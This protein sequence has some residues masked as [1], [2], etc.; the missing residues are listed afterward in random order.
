MLLLSCVAGTVAWSLDD[1]MTRGLQVIR[2]V[3]LEVRAATAL[4]QL[5]RRS[6]RFRLDAGSTVPAL[7][8]GASRAR[9][10]PA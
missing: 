7:P 4:I 9:P 2:Q 3:P 6:N 10:V 5:P 1:D 8:A